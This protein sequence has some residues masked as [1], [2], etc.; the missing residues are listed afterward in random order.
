M[1]GRMGRGVEWRAEA[2]MLAKL[3][4]ECISGKIGGWFYSQAK[5]LGNP[6]AFDFS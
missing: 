5:N 4:A 2:T 3:S 1:W 6:Q